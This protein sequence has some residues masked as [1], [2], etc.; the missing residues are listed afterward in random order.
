VLS[1]PNNIA[2]LKKLVF[3]HSCL[4]FKLQIM[5]AMV[6]SIT[7][8]RKFVSKA[9]KEERVLNNYLRISDQKGSTLTASLVWKNASNPGA[10][11]ILS[12]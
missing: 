11:P 4:L 9:N 3:N 12:L 10:C 2:Q 7:I 6:C 5:L 1:K 8:T